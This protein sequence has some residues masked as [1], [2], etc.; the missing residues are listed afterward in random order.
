[1]TALPELAELIASL[2]WTVPPP[3]RVSVVRLPDDTTNGFRLVFER[4]DDVLRV[5]VDGSPLSFLRG[6]SMA[7]EGWYELGGA[8]GQGALVKLHLAQ[9]VNLREA[10]RHSLQCAVLAVGGTLLPAGDVR[11]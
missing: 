1:M 2:P 11:E 8:K 9:T 6:L 10:A 5:K 7:V 3:E 4:G